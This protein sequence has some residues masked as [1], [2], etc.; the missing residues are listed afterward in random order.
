LSILEL[1][2]ALD[3]EGFKEIVSCEGKIVVI[4]LKPTVPVDL[5]HQIRLN[6]PE[7]VPMLRKVTREQLNASRNVVGQAPPELG[8]L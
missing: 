8:D 5:A 3:D 6:T 7:L 4:G 2:I 1:L